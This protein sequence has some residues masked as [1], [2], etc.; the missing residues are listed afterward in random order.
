VLTMLADDHAEPAEIDV[1]RRVYGEIAGIELSDE[2]IA[3]DIALARRAPVDAAVYCRAIASRR[4]EDER[5]GIVR[6]AFLIA[7][8]CGEISAE[9]LEQLKQLPKAFGMSED[10]FRG[11]IA[12]ASG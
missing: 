5:N 2:D 12:E 9:R 1:L 11:I 6:G 3:R 10:R 8:A 7:S 4:A